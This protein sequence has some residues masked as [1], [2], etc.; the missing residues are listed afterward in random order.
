[1]TKQAA[2]AYCKER[3]VNVDL[4]HGFHE[5]IKENQCFSDDPCPLSEKF[6][7]TAAQSDDFKIVRLQRRT[8]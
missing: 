6:H 7:P 3:K 8:T 1:M 2:P 5:C 4:R